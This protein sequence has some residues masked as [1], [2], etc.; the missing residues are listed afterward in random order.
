MA[1]T[2][3]LLTFRKYV[4]QGT[5]GWTMTA[6]KISSISLE[7]LKTVYIDATNT[8]RHYDGQRTSFAQI[9]VALLSILTTV[10]TAATLQGIAAS[11]VP[12]AAGVGTVLSLISI[13]AVL[14]F[15][16]LIALQRKRAA[17]AM[18]CYEEK[19][20]DIDLMSINRNA[21]LSLRTKISARIDLGALWVAMFVVLALANVA[22]LWFS[23]R[24]LVS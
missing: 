8:I 17:I 13:L 19:A 10:I 9:F 15:D 20:G 11:L 16:G 12:M 23:A 4:W 5:L 1:S 22:I 2:A 7:F 14:K 6:N 3:C 21:K 18:R 24:R